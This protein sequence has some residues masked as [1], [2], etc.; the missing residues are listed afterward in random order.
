MLTIWREIST[1]TLSSKTVGM[2]LQGG[3]TE[4]SERQNL[5]N[6]SQIPH[7]LTQKYFCLKDQAMLGS[8]R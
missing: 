7:A 1:K 8:I 3:H 6:A 4:L 2:C 5:A